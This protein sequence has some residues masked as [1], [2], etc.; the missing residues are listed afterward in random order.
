MDRYLE[1]KERSFSWQMTESKI[2]QKKNYTNSLILL[3]VHVQHR[4]VVIVLFQKHELDVLSFS[5]KEV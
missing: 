4:I 2:Y 5:I 1:L 3:T